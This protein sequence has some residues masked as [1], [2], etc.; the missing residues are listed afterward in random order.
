MDEGQHQANDDEKQRQKLLP[1]VTK[2]RDGWLKFSIS[3]RIKFFVVGEDDV[4]VMR[5]K[6][7]CFRSANRPVCTRKSGNLVGKQIER[8]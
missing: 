5:K 6:M 3:G 7:R 8:K 2:D 4:S 1:S